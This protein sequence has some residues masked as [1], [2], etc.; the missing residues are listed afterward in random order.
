MYNELTLIKSVEAI[1]GF[2]LENLEVNFFT[3]NE[4]KII[5]HKNFV[6]SLGARYLIKKMIL[7]YLAIENRYKDIEIENRSTGKPIIKFTGTV[8]EKIK[9]SGIT[10]VQISVSHSRNFI[11]SIV[12][13]EQDV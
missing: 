1:K 12:I 4:L 6:K 3:E 11:T 8:K 13:L 2:F 10:N 5:E 9:E 7:E